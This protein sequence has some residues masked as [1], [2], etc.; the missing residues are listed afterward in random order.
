MNKLRKIRNNGN[1][2]NTFQTKVVWWLQLKSKR[3]EKA[4]IN[5]RSCVGRGGGTAMKNPVTDMTGNLEKLGHAWGKA[6]RKLPTQ[7]HTE[8][9]IYTHNL[10]YF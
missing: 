7:R 5:N 10:D 8:T 3:K 6:E 4:T 9:Y 2:Q 1:N